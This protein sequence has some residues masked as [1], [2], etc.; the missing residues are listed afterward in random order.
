MFSYIHTFTHT[1]LKYINT[2]IYQRYTSTD[3]QLRC[4]HVFMYTCIQ[5]IHTF[6]HIYMYT[7]KHI[8]TC[9]QV[10]V[11][12]QTYVETFHVFLPAWPVGHRNHVDNTDH[13]FRQVVLSETAVV[14]YKN[15]TTDS[16]RNHAGDITLNLTPHTMRLKPKNDKKFLEQ[17]VIM[18][19]G[20]STCLAK[21][22]GSTLNL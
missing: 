2:C 6:I 9:A 11:H 10:Y 18:D 8:Y 3:I 12:T 22:T 4:I 20:L 1:S 21:E 7:N 13:T 15:C 5:N 14:P 16:L 17:Y 19:N